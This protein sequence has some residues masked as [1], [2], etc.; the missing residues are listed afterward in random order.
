MLRT[1]TTTPGASRRWYEYKLCNTYRLLIVP[2][3]C[4]DPDL[5]RVAAFR[6][7]ERLPTLSW[8]DVDTGATLW[9]ASQP[10]AGVSGSS[11]FDEKF[12]DFLAK[13]CVGMPAAPPP[14]R[15]GPGYPLLFIVDCRP[16][17]SAIANR[18]AGAGY[19][20]QT[21]YPN[22]RLEFYNIGNIHVMRDSLKSLCGL[23]LSPVAAG[24]GDE[25]LQGCRGHRVAVPRATHP[26]GL[27]RLG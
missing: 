2:A 11:E 5:Y 3:A 23:V 20:T 7:G 22:T 27:L 8:G 4:T 15:R 10:K 13:S 9:R 12:L 16:R 14:T 18:A 17:A 26:Q 6:S 24:S 19:E 21:N 25:L 1:T